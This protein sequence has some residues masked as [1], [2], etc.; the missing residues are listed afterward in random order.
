MRASPRRRGQSCLVTAWEEES[1]TERGLFENLAAG[2]RHD[3][4]R[5]RKRAAEYLLAKSN[6]VII[7]ARYDTR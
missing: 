7:G 3:G 4:R 2:V 5:S 6:F 1:G